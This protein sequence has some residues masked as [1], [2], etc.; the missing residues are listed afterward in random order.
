MIKTPK[1][2]FEDSLPIIDGQLLRFKHKWTLTGVAWLDF[3]DV[4]QIIRIHIWKKWPSYDPDKASIEAWSYRVI[5]NQLKNVIRNLYGNF[6]KPCLKCEA[7]E[8]DE[9]CRVYG[10]QCIDCPMYSNWETNKKHAHDIRLP[11][12]IENHTQEVFNLPDETSDIDEMAA[13]LHVKMEKILKPLEWKI[14]KYLYIDRKNEEETARLM[15]Y[16][17]SEANKKPG[18]KYIK[19]LK[20]AIIIKVKKQLA[21]DNNE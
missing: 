18:Y 2:S 11:V 21:K 10:K 6:S 3:S 5:S 12:T 7:A 20:M 19:K 4:S 1:L 13:V 17:T 16:K 8:G 15:G 9:G 14:Y